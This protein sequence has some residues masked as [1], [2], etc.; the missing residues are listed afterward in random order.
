MYTGKAPVPDP[1]LV[2]RLDHPLLGDV[3]L[4]TLFASGAVFALAQWGLLMGLLCG[5]VLGLP[6][7]ALTSF[8]HRRLARDDPRGLRSRLLAC[9]ALALVLAALTTAWIGPA[10]LGVG[11]ALFTATA[12]RTWLRDRSVF[13]DRQQSE[14][15]APPP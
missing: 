14:A 5:I 2:R 11:A 9:L 13:K 8:V 7:I 10:G 6:A 1:Y 15:I 4:A 12:A 3:Y